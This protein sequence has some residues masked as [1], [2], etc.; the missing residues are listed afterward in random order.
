MAPRPGKSFIFQLSVLPHTIDV[1]ADGKHVQVGFSLYS[2]KTTVGG[3]GMM[4][5]CLCMHKMV[6]FKI[7]ET[8]DSSY[9]ESL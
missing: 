7:A 4:F 3:S 1:R 5:K 8:K 6:W 9:H 2:K